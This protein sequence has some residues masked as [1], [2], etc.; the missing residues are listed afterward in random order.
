MHRL[1]PVFGLALALCLPLASCDRQSATVRSEA[2]AAPDATA[3]PDAIPVALPETVSFNEHIQPI[4]S[5][6]CY[7]CHGPDSGTREPKSAPLRLDIEAD[8]FALR[9]NGK[10]VIIKGNPK[11]SLMVKLM[12]EKDPEF[13][14]PP[15]ASH[16]T[17]D[18]GKIALLEKWIEQGAPYEAHWSFLP[19]TRPAAPK[20]GKGR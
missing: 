2:P 17:L 19:I 16:K 13:I 9:E 14:M 15:P 11:D 7:H 20:A 3:A 4:L 12:H 1:H 6:Y 5:E 8:A 18:A 10:P